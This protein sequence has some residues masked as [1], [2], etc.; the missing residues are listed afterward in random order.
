[1]YWL[2]KTNVTGLLK[3]LGSP[4]LTDCDL[5]VPKW[6]Q[7]RSCL[8]VLV[9]SALET[10]TFNHKLETRL[11]FW[12]ELLDLTNKVLLWKP[13]FFLLRLL[14]KMKSY[15]SYNDLENRPG[16]QNNSII[17]SV[18]M[19]VQSSLGAARLLTGTGTRELIGPVSASLHLLPVCSRLEWDIYYL[20]LRF[21]K[22]QHLLI[23]VNRCAFILQLKLW[24]R[25]VRRFQMF[26]VRTRTQ[27]PPC[28]FSGCAWLVE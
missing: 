5:S 21:E 7:E 26:Q 19:W 23:H 4:N 22:A 2:L 15:P 1:M 12:T 17:V 14:V 9:L 24:S 13:A 6:R 27:R 20:F 25:P 18:C 3:C 11:W 10:H 8:A 28:V 16:F